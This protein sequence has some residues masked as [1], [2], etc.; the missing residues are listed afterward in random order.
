MEYL[1]IRTCYLL[2]LIF[3]TSICSATQTKDAYYGEVITKIDQTD[4]V[5]CSG[6][7]SDIS[8][9]TDKINPHNSLTIRD[10]LVIT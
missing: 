9:N 5:L 2:S 7:S 4:E 10:I 3:F 8:K 6:I 1:M